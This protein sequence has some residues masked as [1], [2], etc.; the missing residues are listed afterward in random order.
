MRARGRTGL[1]AVALALATA[2]AGVARGESRVPFGGTLEMAWFSAPTTLDPAEALGF[3]EVEAARLIYDTPFRLDAEGRPVPHLALS[4]EVAPG[5]RKARLEIRPGVQFHD[6]TA[7]TAADVAASLSRARARVG[8][9]VLGPI[10]A[11][12]AISPT[13]LE[14]TLTRKTPELPALLA[15]PAAAVTPRGREPGKL[16]IGSGPFAIEKWGGAGSRE[17]TLVAFPRHFAGR[18]FLE[19]IV[20]RSFGARQGESAAYERG[21]IGWSYR[22]AVAFPDRK[23]RFP[24]VSLVSPAVATVFVGFGVDHAWL[25][26]L[27]VR[28]AIRWAID[29]DAARAAGGVTGA[30]AAVA[31][32]PPGLGAPGN[33]KD[34]SPGTP[35]AREVVRAQGALALAAG[36]EPDLRDFMRQGGKLSILVDATR[37]EDFDV[38][39]K[40]LDMLQGIGLD[41]Q[42]EKLEPREFA[43]R[44]AAG[45][46][47]LF[48]GSAVAP[49]SD[50]AW[51]AAAAAAAAGDATRVRAELARASLTVERMHALIE[52]RVVLIPLFHH[53]FQIHHLA[54][55]RGVGAGVDP[56]ARLGLGD[57]WLVRR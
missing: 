5:G 28:H 34:V 22:G 46:C 13:V 11:A 16:P 26:D 9:W 12:Q 32:A 21:A 7:L 51:A 55:L 25:R 19:R 15:A 39:L 57:L 33:G 18:P 31:E 47:D 50:R 27:D 41:G 35:P 48:L 38:A 4:L 24:T 29:R 40:L 14:L 10:R 3:S 42:V 2:T 23:P 30:V 36:R 45:H 1:L 6:G 8:G 54:A 52:E 56:L 53:P 44:V 37:P 43:V 20:T 49:A 17:L